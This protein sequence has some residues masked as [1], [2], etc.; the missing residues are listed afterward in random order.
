MRW[1]AC[2]LPTYFTPNDADARDAIGTV[3]N[4]LTGGQSEPLTLHVKGREDKCQCDE[5]RNKAD[6]MQRKTEIWTGK[7]ELTATCCGGM[8][9]H[10]SKRGGWQNQVCVEC[11]GL[12]MRK[13]GNA[14]CFNYI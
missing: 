11:V 12:R 10:W 5:Q 14:A 9:V 2:S 13:G 3:W 4:E 7:A 1:S 6:H 8:P